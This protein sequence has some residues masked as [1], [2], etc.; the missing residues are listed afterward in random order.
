MQFNSFSREQHLYKCPPFLSDKMNSFSSKHSA[1]L[2][3]ASLC[4]LFSLAQADPQ[5]TAR[6]PSSSSSSPS[7]NLDELE[8][9][10]FMLDAGVPYRDL[11]TIG[12]SQAVAQFANRFQPAEKDRVRNLTWLGIK[13]CLSIVCYLFWKRMRMMLFIRVSIIYCTSLLLTYLCRIHQK[14]IIYL[15][16]HFLPFLF[17]KWISI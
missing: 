3:L 9:T 4:V 7:Q 5:F 1:H 17:R 11:L 16:V 15:H 13:Y 12:A 2:S 8:G 14:G 6:Y 10:P